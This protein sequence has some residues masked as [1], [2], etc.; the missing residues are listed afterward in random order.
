MFASIDMTE[1]RRTRLKS[2][3]FEFPSPKG[4]VEPLRK[5]SG[6]D[7]LM[8]QRSSVPR[9]S[10]MMAVSDDYYSHL[11]ATGRPEESI[12]MSMKTIEMLALIK[13]TSPEAVYVEE[14]TRQFGP[15][16]RSE[17]GHTSTEGSSVHHQSTSEEFELNF[18]DDYL[19]GESYIGYTEDGNLA[20]SLDDELMAIERSMKKNAH[21]SNLHSHRFEERERGERTFEYTGYPGESEDEPEEAIFDLE[22]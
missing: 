20:G 3:Q 15:H 13:G 19:L 14:M 21:L 4:E 5:Y 6:N 1:G 12:E 11:A 2:N 9:R 17:D 16:S 8:Y 18:D 22:L 7:E 10:P